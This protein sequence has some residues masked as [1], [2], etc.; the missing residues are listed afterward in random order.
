M[1]SIL[2]YRKDMSDLD[3]LLSYTTQ[4]TPIYVGKERRITVLRN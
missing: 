3:A 4:V 2:Y 1:S